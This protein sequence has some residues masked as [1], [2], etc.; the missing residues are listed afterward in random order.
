MVDG[1]LTLFGEERGVKYDDGNHEIRLKLRW[2]LLT[3]MIGTR[4]KTYDLNV[5]VNVRSI[6]VFTYKDT[7][8]FHL[9]RF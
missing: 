1:T 5:K 3:V 4:E 2:N 8:E 6:E 9:Y 7:V